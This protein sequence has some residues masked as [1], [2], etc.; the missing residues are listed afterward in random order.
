VGAVGKR[1]GGQYDMRDTAG[2]AQR[3]IRVDTRAVVISVPRASLIGQLVTESFE[4]LL[5]VAARS[6]T[7]EGVGERQVQQHVPLGYRNC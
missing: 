5:L 3:P 6:D 1:T 2:P 4:D 7:F